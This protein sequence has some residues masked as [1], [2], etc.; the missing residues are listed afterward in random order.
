MVAAGDSAQ[1]ICA[2]TLN[3]VAYSVKKA[4]EQL[5]ETRKLP[6]LVSGGVSVCSFIQRAFAVMD[7]V[8]FARYGL[9]GDNA[10]GAAILCARAEGC[11]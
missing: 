8:Y 2:F 3:T 11:L 1:D 9:G 6:V 7:D 5:L 10:L 4:T